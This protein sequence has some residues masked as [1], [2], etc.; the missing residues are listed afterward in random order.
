MHFTSQEIFLFI[1]LVP[2]LIF[3]G[4]KIR[5]STAAEKSASAEAEKLPPEIRRKFAQGF[6][7]EGGP[8]LLAV[9]DVN[10]EAR[11]VCELLLDRGIYARV[12]G[13]V[14]VIVHAR[15]FAAAGALLAEHRRIAAGDDAGWQRRICPQCGS[16]MLSYQKFHPS[17]LILLLGAP[18]LPVK[19]GRWICLACGHKWK[20]NNQK[21]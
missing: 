20:E 16:D 7:R 5:G 2:V 9:F 8:A 14:Q 1:V 19:T 12:E 13:G 18:F 11:I 10:S 21:G 6:Y 15:E 4:K 17:A 3:I